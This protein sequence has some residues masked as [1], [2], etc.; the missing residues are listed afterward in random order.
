MSGLGSLTVRRGGAGARLVDRRHGAFDCRPEPR[1]FGGGERFRSDLTDAGAGR[2]RQ[3]IAGALTDLARPDR[4]AEA[5]KERPRLPYRRRLLVL[6]LHWRCI[7]HDRIG[8]VA[9]ARGS[10]RLAHAVETEEAGTGRAKN[11]DWGADGRRRHHPPAP[12][13]IDKGPFVA[14]DH[15]SGERAVDTAGGAAQR[16]SAVGA[17]RM[18]EA[19][20]A[21]RIGVD[22][23]ATVAGV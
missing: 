8:L 5:V 17:E 23:H 11:E 4:D 2:E 19:E 12:G 21:L 7:E 9:F 15:R 3:H 13:G 22:N 14:L 6:A 16:R 20:R 10:D 1:D 18:P